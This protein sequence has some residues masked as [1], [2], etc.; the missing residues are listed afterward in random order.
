MSNLARLSG[1]KFSSLIDLGIP[2]NDGSCVTNVGMD[3]EVALIICT[4]GY[5]INVHGVAETF[6]NAIP[7]TP[8]AP[9]AADSC[10]RTITNCDELQTK[11]A[12]VAVTVGVGGGVVFEPLP[13]PARSNTA[14]ATAE[15]LTKVFIARSYFLAHLGEK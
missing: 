15:T 1:A 3:F 4:L 12:G 5:P 6:L 2:I 7:V 10:P 14:I 8:L 9:I 13:Q 11:A